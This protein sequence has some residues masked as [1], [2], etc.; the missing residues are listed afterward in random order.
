MHLNYPETIPPLSGPWKNC[1]SR[2][3]SLV[4]KR[5]GTA[6][7]RD[8]SSLTRDSKLATAVKALSPNPWTAREFPGFFISSAQSIDLHSR[9]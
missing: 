1:L 4:P 7:L 2:N 3:Q 8:L 9:H 6:G 5:L